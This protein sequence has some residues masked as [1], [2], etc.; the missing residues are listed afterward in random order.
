MEGAGALGTPVSPVSPVSMLDFGDEL[1]EQPADRTTE[2]KKSKRI[3]WAYRV[4]VQEGIHVSLAAQR[5]RGVPAL[6]RA[7]PVFAP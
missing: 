6:N 7:T 2:E 5:A 1:E 4:G 3:I